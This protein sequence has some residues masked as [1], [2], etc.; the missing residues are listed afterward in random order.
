MVKKLKFSV[1]TLDINYVENVNTDN[2]RLF[3]L[4]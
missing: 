1:Y 3:D 4:Y 2:M